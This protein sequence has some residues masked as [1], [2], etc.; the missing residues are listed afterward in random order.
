MSKGAKICK[1]REEPFLLNSMGYMYG[2]LRESNLT[3]AWA[4]NT[5]IDRSHSEDIWSRSH[6][7]AIK[8]NN[9]TVNPKA[10]QFRIPHLLVNLTKTTPNIERKIKQWKKRFPNM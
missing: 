1:L 6:W 7:R 5:M 8:L 4:E 3:N 10:R 9:K 2:T